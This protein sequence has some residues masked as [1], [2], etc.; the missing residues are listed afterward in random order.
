MP[1]PDRAANL[2]GWARLRGGTGEATIG[3]MADAMTQA[4]V[5]DLLGRV[6]ALEAALREAQG[7]IVAL[8]GRLASGEGQRPPVAQG[9]PGKAVAAP[10][11]PKGAKGKAGATVTP[12]EAHRAEERQ[13]ILDALEATGW[14]RLEAAKRL[15]LARRT[16]HR[17]LKEYAIQ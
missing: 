4:V 6:Q 12:L 10:S 5:Q 11:A 13:R 15:G 1:W 14:N 3:G 9:A 2:S 8:E 16:F 7:R 17:R